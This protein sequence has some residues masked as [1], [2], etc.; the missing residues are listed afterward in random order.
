MTKRRQW[1][2]QFGIQG[3]AIFSSDIKK[4][5]CRANRMQNF[6]KAAGYETNQW[7]HASLSRWPLDLKTAERK[8]PTELVRRQRP[9]DA[10]ETGAHEL[11]YQP[12][13]ML[14]VRPVI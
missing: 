10:K 5:N 3:I 1:R 8:P 11:M 12:P 14:I 4:T 9:A 13:L 6:F 7:R 2:E